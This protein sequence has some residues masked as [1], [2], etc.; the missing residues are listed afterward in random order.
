[1]TEGEVPQTPIEGPEEEAWASWLVESKG[2]VEGI[3][4]DALRT[5]I[6]LLA[7]RPD[8]MVTPEVLLGAYDRIDQLLRERKVTD[9]DVAKWQARIAMRHEGIAQHGKPSEF[10]PE[11]FAKA[12]GVSG[13]E[14]QIKL[15][16]RAERA[17]LPIKVEVGSEPKFWP[18][19]DE[20]KQEEWKAR[21]S[22]ATAAAVK[23]TAPSYDKL[24]PNDEAIGLTKADVEV[25]LGKTEREER[26]RG[27]FEALSVYVALISDNK[28]QESAL[29]KK[30]ASKTNKSLPASFFEIKDLKQVL[31]VRTAMENW[32]KTNFKLTDEEAEDAEHI[33]WNFLYLSNIVEFFDSRLNGRPNDSK[34]LPP[35]PGLKSL[36]VWM[37]MHPEERLEAKLG[38]GKEEAES[39]SQLGEWALDNMRRFPGW[40][41]A[42][43]DILPDTLFETV[44]HEI[45]LNGGTMYEVLLENG[46]KL[47]SNPE[48]PLNEIDFAKIREN[49]LTTYYFDKVN[50]AIFVF[51]VVD[52]GSLEKRISDLGTACRKLK[53][54]K[55]Y[56][57]TVLLAHYGVNTKA[58]SL[59]YVGG[60]MEW[61]GI[62]RGINKYAPNFFD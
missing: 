34:R 46:E 49:P 17:I 31:A 2:E 58:K 45:K 8:S 16:R 18:Y 10:T 39:W 4:E 30:W 15:Y 1:M 21:G 12:L 19:I 40:T 38:G 54:P 36:P 29:L 60:R 32:L 52:T 9:E 56:R 50:P 61:F 6:R 57:E 22:L 14:E 24:F 23:R 43:E 44:F 3:K 48:T 26:K 5:E 55:K 59:K 11:D 28:G 42:T 53:M 47:I 7:R 35:I 25:L 33:A 37:I 20:E 13:P 62:L 51:S 27:A 41:P